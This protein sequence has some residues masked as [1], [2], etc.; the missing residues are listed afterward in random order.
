MATQINRRVRRGFSTFLIPLL[1]ACA[2]AP[3]PVIAPPTPTTLVG[4]LDSI[5]AD[6]AL[7]HAHWGVLVK[8]LDTGEIIYERNSRK[9]FIPASTMKLVTGA[10]G[11]VSLGPDYRYRTTFSISGPVRAGTLQGDLVVRGSG[12]PTLSERFT[13]DARATMRAW[14]DSLRA[15]GITRIAGGIVGVDSAFVGPPLGAGWAWDDLDTYY[16]A[17]VGALQFNEGAIDLQ[18]VPSRTVGEPAIVILDPATQYVH[19]NNRTTTVQRGSTAGLQ[20]ARDP[21]GPGITLSGIVPV[22]TSAIT[23]TVTVRDP[24]N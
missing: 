17:E 4:A 8:S 19:V 6:T 23:V 1:A 12:D 14:A 22:D 24:A 21:A 3:R 15:H 9:A 2:A 7:Q 11:L 20:I 5:F 16:A 13:S 10:A 18:V